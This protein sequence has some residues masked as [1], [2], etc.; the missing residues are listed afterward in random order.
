MSRFHRAQD[1]AG[2]A[3]TTGSNSLNITV[4]AG[5]CVH[6]NVVRLGCYAHDYAHGIAFLCRDCNAYM[7]GWQCPEV[8]P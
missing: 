1:W 8:R 5:G 7:D 2:G 6:E 4:E 3:V